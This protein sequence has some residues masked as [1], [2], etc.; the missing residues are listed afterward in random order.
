ME[1]YNFTV[2]DRIS[3]LDDDIKGIVTSVEKFVISIEDED[4]FI[5]HFKPEE[6]VK[7]NEDIFKN[8]T[9]NSTHKKSEDKKQLKKVVIKEE[10][11]IEVDLHIHK[12]THSN[13]FM[14][15]YDML[16]AQLNVAKIQLE[17]AINTKKQR[18]VFIHGKGQGVLKTELLRLLKKYPV[19]INDGNFKKYGLGATEVRIFLSKIK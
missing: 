7:V 1:K 13:K 10:S 16:N 3:V 8:I 9:V 2:G 18:L 17:K 12:I 19:E 11:I 15:N 6:L 4:G 5:R 14:S